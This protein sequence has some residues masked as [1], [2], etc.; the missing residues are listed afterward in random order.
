MTVGCLILQQRYH[1]RFSR[2][3]NLAQDVSADQ[4]PSPSS[5]TE[6]ETNIEASSAST[7]ADF[8]A[9][10]LRNHNCGSLPTINEGCCEESPVVDIEDIVSGSTSDIKSL[11]PA[12]DND[13]LCPSRYGCHGPKRQQCHGIV[14]QYQEQIDNDLEYIEEEPESHEPQIV[15]HTVLLIM[16]LCSVFVVS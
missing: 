5:S 2:Y 12:S 13:G 14:R 9:S 10:T 15:R 1:R 7:S 11:L 3:L 6:A 4:E 16:L 8:G